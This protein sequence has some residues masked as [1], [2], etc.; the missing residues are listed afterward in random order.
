[1]R[2]RPRYLLFPCFFGI[3][4]KVVPVGMRDFLVSMVDLEKPYG[5]GNVLFLGLSPRGDETQAPEGR[6]GLIAQ[7]LIP[8]EGWERTSWTF[9][10]E[11]VVNHLNQIIPFLENYLDF[12]DFEW[13]GRQ[14]GRWSYP[15]FLYETIGPFDW[16]AGV[17]PT[18]L[19]KDLYF[20]GKENF[21]Y[22]GLEGQ[23]LSGL[24]VAH[25]VLKK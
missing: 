22:L 20:I 16:R 11:S 21:P 13:A 1:M 3:R 9:L 25:Q 10:Q 8:F 15:H 24:L 23:V 5:G 2:I 18:Q 7:T 17:I 14:V 6:R 19:S 12:F 4:E